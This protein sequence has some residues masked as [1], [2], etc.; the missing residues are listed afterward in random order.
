MK[1][2]NENR[3]IV[4]ILGAPLIVFLILFNQITFSVLIFFIV[5]FS[6]YE[7]TSL[8]KKNSKLTIYKLFLGFF[9]ISSIIY[10]LPIH[11]FQDIGKNFTLIIFIAVWVTDSMAFIMGKAFG[12]KKIFPSVSPNKTWVGTLSGLLFSILFLLLIYFNDD[13]F[14]DN[15]IKIWPVSFN[16]FDVVFLGFIT[17]IFSQF[18]DFSESYFKRKLNVKDSSQLLLGHGGFLDRFDSMF[19]V[20]ITTYFYLLLNGHYYG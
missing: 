10:F 18:G 9:W 17:G 11:N 16:E 20:G 2:N 14:N 4:N 19:A 7:Y 15:N 12:K 1:I 3:T 8:I 13:Y 6:L 5:F